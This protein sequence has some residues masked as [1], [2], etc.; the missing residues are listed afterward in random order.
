M[1]KIQTLAHLWFTNANELKYNLR[2]NYVNANP[3]T[4]NIVKVRN[5][6]NSTYTS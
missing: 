2:Q 3:H 6:D 5:W 4:F 1:N